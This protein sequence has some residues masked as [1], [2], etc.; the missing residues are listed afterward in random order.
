M[1]LFGFW[2]GVIVVNRASSLLFGGMICLML[3]YTPVIH[4][5]VWHLKDPI[6]NVLQTMTALKL[7]GHER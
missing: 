3:G 6:Y 5:D 1:I 4:W 2:L 7:D